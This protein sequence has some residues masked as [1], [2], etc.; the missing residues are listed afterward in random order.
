MVGPRRSCI[1]P[2]WQQHGVTS[3]AGKGADVV[4]ACRPARM[5]FLAEADWRKVMGARGVVLLG[6]P[7][8]E[9]RDTGGGMAGGNVQGTLIAR[10]ALSSGLGAAM[11]RWQVW[12]HVDAFATTNSDPVPATCRV[13]SSAALSPDV[14]THLQPAWHRVTPRRHLCVCGC[15]FAGGADSVWP[16]GLCGVTSYRE[17][18][19]VVG[20][21][22]GS[23]EH[24]CRLDLL[25]HK[26]PYTDD[27]GSL[28]ESTIAWKP[29]SSTRIA[30]RKTGQRV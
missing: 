4:G 13:S 2:W 19:V 5:V 11:P 6:R 23:G 27:P 25:H 9:L 8:S 1:K 20:G 14:E 26:R 16:G 12:L 21:K 24:S 15:P 7:S 30:A 28:L 22:L 10:A 29:K 18:R 3:H 17:T